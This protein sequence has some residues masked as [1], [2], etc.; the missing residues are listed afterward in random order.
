MMIT[1]SIVGAIQLQQASAAKPQWCYTDFDSVNC[2]YTSHK[3]CRQAQSS[4][5]TAQTRC[6][7]SNQ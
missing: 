4:D 2:G 6:Y 3:A 5:P 1:M 7:N